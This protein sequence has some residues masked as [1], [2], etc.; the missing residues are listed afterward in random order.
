MQRQ[1]SLSRNVV[2]FCR[3]LRGHNFTIGVGEEATALAALQYIDYRQVESF[4]LA[5]RAVLCRS[6]AQ[7]VLFDNLY[8]NYWKELAQAIESKKLERE[9]KRAK[10][11][12]AASFKAIK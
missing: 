5:L 7:L 3:Y 12:P 8:R 2:Q 6:E 10:T 4:R 9:R 1:T 11:N